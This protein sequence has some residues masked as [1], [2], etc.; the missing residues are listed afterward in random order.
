M[1]SPYEQRPWNNPVLWQVHKSGSVNSQSRSQ[2]RNSHKTLFY[3]LN[4]AVVYAR[5]LSTITKYTTTYIM[6]GGQTWIDKFGTI[7]PRIIHDKLSCRGWLNSQFHPWAILKDRGASLSLVI[8]AFLEFF[9]IVRNGSLCGFIKHKVSDR[10]KCQV[11]YM[12]GL[13]YTR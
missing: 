7:L 6:C 2:S 5:V 9:S 1:I 10:L 3:N 4:N 11:I 12:Q 8:N 13:T